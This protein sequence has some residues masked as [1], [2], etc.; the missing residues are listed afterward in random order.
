MG[1]LLSLLLPVLGL[2]AG[3]VAALPARAADIPAAQQALLLLKVLAYD[4]QLDERIREGR[5]AI[6]HRT[7]HT[8]SEA[9]G[10]DLMAA[11]EEAT[12][13]FEVS[14]HRLTAGVF[15][16]ASNEA[17][18]EAIAA[19]PVAVYLCPGIE[20]QLDSILAA[21]AAHDALTF[22]AQTS[23]IDAGTSIGLVLEGD[24][25]RMVVNLT[26]S[27]EEGARLSASLLAVSDV[28]R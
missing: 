25:P 9:C 4:K 15:A 7:G 22:T 18:E 8:E 13:S 17:V 3:T 11:L 16:V 21:S 26:T 23:F 19:G 28:R 1:S 14:G 10:R 27:R 6:L 5:L 20:E 24:R 2:L 12:S